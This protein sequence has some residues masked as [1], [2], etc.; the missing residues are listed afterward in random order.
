LI[1]ASACYIPFITLMRPYLK[2]FGQ[3]FSPTPYGYLVKLLYQPLY[4]TAAFGI[5]CLV[6]YLLYDLIRRW[7]IIIKSSWNYFI[8]IP[9]KIWCYIWCRKKKPIVTY[10][11]NEENEETYIQTDLI[12]QKLEELQTKQDESLTK[13]QED[14]NSQKEYLSEIYNKQKDDLKQQ[15]KVLNQQHVTDLMK[16]IDQLQKQQLQEDGTSD[17]K[18]QARGRNTKCVICLDKPLLIALKP[19]GHVCACHKCAKKLPI[20][21]ECPICRTVITGTLKVYFP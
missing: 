17:S 21:G 1:T 10:D 7:L 6:F 20:H 12:L 18:E 16:K 3:K 13:Q 4:W 2:E 15:Q 5:A 11:Y 8:R 14:F 9:Y 19:C